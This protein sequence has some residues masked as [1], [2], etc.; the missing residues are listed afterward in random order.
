MSE[1]IADLP[2]RV[3]DADGED[4]YVS[5]AG[6]A[7][8]DG[9]WQAWLEYVPGDES[10]PLLTPIETTQ[11]TRADV[12]RWAEA[13]TETYVE[14]AFSRAVSADRDLLSAFRERRTAA[15]A[16]AEAVV[17]AVRGDL[18][19]P[20]ELYASGRAA[21]RVRLNALPRTTLLE[22]IDTFGLNPAGKSLSW[23]SRKARDVH[24]DG[25]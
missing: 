12:L 3:I 6:E 4:Y 13:L 8:T 24:R 11:Q 19:D 1:V 22:I 21:M 17:D 15:A 2:Y 20:F 16:S 7:R 5:V 25:R 10:D 14:G 18:P 9:R 23:L